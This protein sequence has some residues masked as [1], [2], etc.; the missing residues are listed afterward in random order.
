M[1]FGGSSSGRGVGRGGGSRGGMQGRGRGRG[2]GLTHE[3]TE[4]EDMDIYENEVNMYNPLFDPGAS[5][6]TD[7]LEKI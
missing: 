2:R 6:G 5:T 4:G 1:K 7:S 3:D